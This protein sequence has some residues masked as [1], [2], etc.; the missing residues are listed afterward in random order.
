[1]ICTSILKVRYVHLKIDFRIRIRLFVKTRKNGKKALAK[2]AHTGKNRVFT[3]FGSFFKNLFPFFY[4]SFFSSKSIKITFYY[5]YNHIID[6]EGK[7][8]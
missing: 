5:I 6:Y 4:F 7:I 2:S 3:H 8:R 1:M